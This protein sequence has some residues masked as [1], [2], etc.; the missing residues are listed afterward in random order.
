VERK[1]IKERKQGGDGLLEIGTL[2][3]ISTY[4]LNL[5]LVSICEICRKKSKERKGLDQAIKEPG[6]TK[7]ETKAL[8]SGN[9]E[10]A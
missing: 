6:F 4:H 8:K 2:D 5:Y 3:A 10:V 9:G 1:K 7:R